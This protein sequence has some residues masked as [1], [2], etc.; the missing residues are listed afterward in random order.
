MFNTREFF[1]YPDY[2]DAL[3]DNGKERLV[4]WY[5]VKGGGLEVSERIG[6]M[7]SIDEAE[8]LLMKYRKN[9]I[10]PSQVRDLIEGGAVEV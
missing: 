5:Q 8:S 7:I 6:L 1:V 2:I 4:Q 9:G 10:G 3:M